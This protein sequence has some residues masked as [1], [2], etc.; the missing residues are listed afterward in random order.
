MEIFA[1]KPVVAPGKEVIYCDQ[2]CNFTIESNS[3]AKFVSLE[4]KGDIYLQN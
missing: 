1:D 4:T 3:L 2:T